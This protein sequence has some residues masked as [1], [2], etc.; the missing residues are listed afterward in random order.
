MSLVITKSGR[1]QIPCKFADI[2]IPD[3]LVGQH[4]A[5]VAYGGRLNPKKVGKV[6][7]QE[8]CN[9]GHNMLYLPPHLVNAKRYVVEFIDGHIEDDIYSDNVYPLSNEELE[10]I[11]LFKKRKKD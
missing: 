11:E 9:F 4:I 10:E 2:K 1:L 7:K 6:I 3:N 8:E 5:I